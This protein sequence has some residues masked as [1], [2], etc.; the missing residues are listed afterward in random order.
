MKK[1]CCEKAILEDLYLHFNE[2]RKMKAQGAFEY[3]VSYGW[4]ILIVIVLGILLF[5]LGVFNPTQT[6]T[7]SG[8]TYLKPVSWSFDGGNAD[9]A[10]VTLAFE[11]VA[12]Q[13]VVAYI[14]DTTQQSI[15]FKQGGSSDCYFNTSIKNITVSDSNGNVL[16]VVQ[17]KVAVPVGSIVTISG[18]IGGAVGSKCGGLKSASYRYNVYV[19]MV[20]EYQVV[21]TDNGLVT[22][23][24]V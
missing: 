3:M 6:P 17:N 11:N 22:G 16:Q 7:A 24:Y 9:S 21:K 19:V 10:N 12:G 4:A 18:A 2:N 13:T 5:S 1:T 8:F 15:K 20:D 14:N 23:K